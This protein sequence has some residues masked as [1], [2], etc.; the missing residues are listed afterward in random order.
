MSA[1]YDLLISGAG[2]V[3]ASLARAIQGCGLR[4]AVIEAVAV[5]AQLQ[6]SYDDRAIALS[7]GSRVILQGLDLWQRI[8]TAAE[9]ILDVHV[10]DRGHFGFARL[11]RRAEQVEALGYVLTA[12]ELGQAL[13]EGLDR[14]VDLMLCP[15]RLVSIRPGRDRVEVAVAAG[16]ELR[17]LRTRLLIA[18]DGGRSL[19]RE[20][21]RIPARERDYGQSAIITNVTPEC[22]H[23][24]TAYER[25]TESGP[26][27]MLPMS[28]QRC[29]VVWTL[30]TDAM[31]EMRT[32]DA[33]A[34]LTRLQDRFGFRLGRLGRLGRRDAYPLK[35][36][37]A[38]ETV[39]PRVVLIG[40][41]AHT[42][43]PVAGQGF[44]LGLRDVAALAEVLADAARLGG[45]P[46]AAEVLHAYEAWRSRDQSTLAWVTDGLVRLF[47]NPVP[48]IRWARNAGLIGLDLAPPFKH[49][50]AGGFM[51]I[52][53]RL[54]R[55][56]RGLPV[57]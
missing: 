56:A 28:R 9:P 12:R 43:H 23:R 26:L 47:T 32:L 36:V 2:M 48:P 4:V 57:A 24:G 25:F 45:D 53:G 3:G 20:L 34:F 10:S 31:D 33:T 27:A 30:P 8:A 39:R 35:Q 37:L 16:D 44:N 42:L 5:D 38:R 22:P 14:R 19:V 15:A 54:P 50:L 1:D 46:G 6:P 40:N 29:G 18:A 13:T 7:W 49:L 11:S 52:G 17:T 51:G 55:L 21:L 41:A